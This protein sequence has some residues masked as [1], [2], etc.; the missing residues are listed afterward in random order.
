MLTR[1]LDTQLPVS[2][3]KILSLA[4]IKGVRLQRKKLE[5]W[6]YLGLP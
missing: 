1:A 4:V 3:P 5:I 2:K 6:P